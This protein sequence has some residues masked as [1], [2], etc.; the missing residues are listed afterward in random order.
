MIELV[1]T[2]VVTAA[3]SRDI[4]QDNLPMVRVYFGDGLVLVLMAD[5]ADQLGDALADVSAAVW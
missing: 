5:T 4:G 3:P 2:P 1:G